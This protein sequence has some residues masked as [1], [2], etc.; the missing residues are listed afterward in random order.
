MTG[1]VVVTVTVSVVAGI[2]HEQTLLIHDG[3]L[4]ETAELSQ[5]L[6]LQDLF[7][8]TTTVLVAVVVL[9]KVSG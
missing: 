4:C 1:P 3:S 8:M 5:F 6:L 2:K 9:L 7:D